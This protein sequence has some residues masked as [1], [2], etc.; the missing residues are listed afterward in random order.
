METTREMGYAN[1]LAPGKASSSYSVP[2]IRRFARTRGFTSE[3]L[4]GAVVLEE[5]PRIVELA[6]SWIISNRGGP[7]GQG[8]RPEHPAVIPVPK[9]SFAALASSS[10]GGEMASPCFKS[11]PTP[12]SATA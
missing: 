9:E 5:N 3:V 7:R 11:V 6:N 10:T 8:K 1:L 12:P 4:G 2:H